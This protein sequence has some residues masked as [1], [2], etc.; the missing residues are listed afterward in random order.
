[1]S[2]TQ[3]HVFLMNDDSPYLTA[4]L[5]SNIPQQNTCGSHKLSELNYLIE[6]VTGQVKCISTTVTKVTTKLDLI[7]ND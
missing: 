3:G 5:V 4:R 2:S 6:T 1:M 7:E